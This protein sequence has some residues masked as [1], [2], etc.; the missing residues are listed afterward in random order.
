MATKRFR[1][2]NGSGAGQKIVAVNNAQ[3]VKGIGSQQ[4][5][6]RILLDAVQL[7]ATT[8]NTTINLFENCKT[9]VFPLT[10]LQENKLQYAESSAMQRFSCYII[11]CAS[12]TTNVLDTVPLSYFSQF[13]RLY[14]AFMSFSIA[15][16]QVIKKFPLTSLQAS[17]NK[18]ARFIGSNQIQPAAGDLLTLNLNH[19][20]FE[21]DN[22]LIIPPQ[23]EFVASFQIP[24]IA[25]PSGFD[26]YFA[27]KIEGLGSLY[28][29]KANY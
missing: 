15:Q 4:G 29:P 9:R 20:V 1:S 25:L 16:D 28:A 27:M 7:T 21:F 2:A 8:V 17:F 6:T 26:F 19:D 12:G 24:P 13:H 18:N 3:G 10:N 5:T 14:G 11:E 23:I 22:D